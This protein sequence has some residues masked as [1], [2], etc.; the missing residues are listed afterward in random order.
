MRTRLIGIGL[1]VAGAIG[2][3]PSDVLSVPAPAGVITSAALENQAGAISALNA[4]KAELFAAADGTF[5]TGLLEGSGLLT[6][7][8]R[9]S[10]FEG[11]A[12]EANVDARITTAEGGF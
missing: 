12:G 7:E 9:F 8:F 4:A 3:R 5:Y 1:A 10:G 6:D 2:C 11:D